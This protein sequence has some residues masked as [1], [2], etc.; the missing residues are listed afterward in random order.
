M[1]AVIFG[2]WLVAFFLLYNARGGA[3][4]PL[5]T[6]DT[7]CLECGGATTAHR[8][9]HAGGRSG[10]DLCECS[11][12]EHITTYVHGLVSRLVYCPDCSQRT[13]EVRET[14]SQSLHSDAPRRLEESCHLCG[15]SRHGH[16]LRIAG[17]KRR[18]KRGLVLR[19]PTGKKDSQD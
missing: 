7:P 18:L 1:W 9:Q 16:L 4:G 11:E 15:Y 12:C 6:R 5:V 13:L 2:L 10:Y 17:A 3:K 14:P 8:I 19:F